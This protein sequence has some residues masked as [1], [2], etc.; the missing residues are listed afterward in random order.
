M[1]LPG[2]EAGN[3]TWRYGAKALTAEHAARLRALTEDTRRI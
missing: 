2:T 3:W 1:N